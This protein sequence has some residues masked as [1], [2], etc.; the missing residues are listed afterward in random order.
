MSPK[1]LILGL[2]A[3]AVLTVIGVSISLHTG[4]TPASASPEPTIL[5]NLTESALAAQLPELQKEGYASATSGLPT[6]LLSKEEVTAW[7][8]AWNDMARCMRVN[9]V[10]DFPDAPVTFGDGL[11]H[12]PLVNAGNSDAFEAAFPKCPFNLGFTPTILNPDSV[13]TTSEYVPPANAKPLTPQEIQDREDAVLRGAQ[14]A[15]N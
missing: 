5:P 9:R 11:T 2:L 10:D 14:A 15:Q 3:V 4:G 7:R 1:R 6:P 13:P 8:S 12:P